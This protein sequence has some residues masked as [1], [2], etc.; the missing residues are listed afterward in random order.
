MTVEEEIIKDEEEL[1]DMQGVEEH[2][3]EYMGVVTCSEVDVGVIIEWTGVRIAEVWGE[4]KDD[5]IFDFDTLYVLWKIDADE[6][7]SGV[8]MS[9][10]PMTPAMIITAMNDKEDISLYI[11]F[12]VI[13]CFVFE[14]FFIMYT[15]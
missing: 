11:K 15:S 3:T 8:E 6:F 13:R 12:T 4:Y 10:K 1:S 14:D 5:D 2:T 9:A 7:G